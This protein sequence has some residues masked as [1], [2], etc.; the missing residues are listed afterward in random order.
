MIGQFSPVPEIR[1]LRLPLSFKLA[2]VRVAPLVLSTLRVFLLSLAVR[3]LS[4]AAINVC[5]SSERAPRDEFVRDLQVGLSS[6]TLS[7]R[8][9]SVSLNC[10]DISTGHF[11]FEKFTF[12][13]SEIVCSCIDFIQ[14]P[15]EAGH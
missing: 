1:I 13:T 3:V 5:A 8:V 9:T 10:C 12:T 7:P 2:I 4:N 11:A 6:S 15:R 14:H